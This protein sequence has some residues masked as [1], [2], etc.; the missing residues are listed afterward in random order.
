VAFFATSAYVAAVLI[1]LARWP[2]LLALVVG[3]L[4]AGAVGFMVGL[5]ALRISGMHLAIVTLALAFVTTELLTQFDANHVEAASGITVTTPDWLLGSKGLYAAAMCA[6]VAAYVVVWTL[7]RS[8]TGRAITAL[9]DHPFAAA[10]V[11]ID[12]TRNRLAVFVLSGMVT[13]VAGSIYLYYSQTVTPQ[14]FPL[15]LSLAFLT[16]MILGG[17]RSIG[18]SILGAFIIGLLPQVLKLFPNQIGSIDVQN[19]IYGLYAVLLLMTLRFF[20]EGLWNVAKHIT[21]SMM[22]PDE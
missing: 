6:A 9:S 14:A 3:V 18:G 10:S 22:R 21:D 2:Y 12:E 7:L 8:R 15:D 11:G 19:S 17:S 1:T 20:P 13:G 5:P 4:A 16:M